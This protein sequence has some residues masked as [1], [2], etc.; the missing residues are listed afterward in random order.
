MDEQIINRV[1]ASSLVTFDLE[2][3]YSP[4]ERVLFD[5][6]DLLF[7][8]IDFERKRFQGFYQ[9]TP[10]VAIHGQICSHYLHR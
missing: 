2:E 5:I 10:M 9:R 7:S 6:K 1:S 3:L 4:G 8:G